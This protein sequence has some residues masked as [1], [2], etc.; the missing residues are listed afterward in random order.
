[1]KNIKIN[2]SSEFEFEIEFE[3]YNN[4][5]FVSLWNV[6]FFLGLRVGELIGCNELQ[7]GVV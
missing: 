6:C 5:P 3:I 2:F 4:V 1:M 7:C